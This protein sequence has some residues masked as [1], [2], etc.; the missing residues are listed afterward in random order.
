MNNMF[1]QDRDKSLNRHAQ[2]TPQR[3][4]PDAALPGH[5]S[6]TQGQVDA[7][8][9]PLTSIQYQTSFMNEQNDQDFLHL[10]M[11]QDYYSKSTNYM[12]M[13]NHFTENQMFSLA[14][15]YSDNVGGLGSPRGMRSLSPAERFQHDLPQDQYQELPLGSFEN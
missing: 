15:P 5:D 1:Q 9:P 13:D 6:H 7:L 8:L 3:S 14:G 2:T 12:E 10:G 11:N 4:S